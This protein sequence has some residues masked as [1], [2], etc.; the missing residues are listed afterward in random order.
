ML[1]LA[2]APSAFPSFLGG[3][4]F[5][6]MNH[7]TAFLDSIPSGQWRFLHAE[8]LG[9]GAESFHDF[10]DTLVGCGGGEGFAISAPHKAST[11]GMYDIVK[12]HKDE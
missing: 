10:V 11:N 5:K 12:V 6:G 1:F 9:M 3:G 2:P 7:F 8:R 4:R